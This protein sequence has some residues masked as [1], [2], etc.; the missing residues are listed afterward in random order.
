MANV[1]SAPANAVA[2][3]AQNPNNAFDV[4]DDQHVTPLDALVAANYLNRTDVVN[5]PTY[6]TSCY[7][8]VNGDGTVSPLDVLMVVNCLERGATGSEANAEGEP[9]LP[10][11]LDRDHA[12]TAQLVVTS[13]L[14][15][16][17]STAPASSRDAG[18]ESGRDEAFARAGPFVAQRPD[19]SPNGR[20][21]VRTFAE[22]DD[23][24]Q[25][26]P[27]LEHDLGVLDAVYAEWV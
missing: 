20:L 10:P 16:S 22:Q 19:E 8:D 2:Y 7:P 25:D 18:D 9:S 13:P 4:N 6:P 23:T 1:E 14:E 24:G 21:C 11:A 26:L 27:A 3:V 5:G 17:P 12:I 15:V